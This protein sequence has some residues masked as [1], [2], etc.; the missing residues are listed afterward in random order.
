VYDRYSPTLYALLLRILGNPAEAQEVLQETFGQVWSNAF[1]FDSTS[2]SEEVWLTAMARSHGVDRLRS[3]RDAGPARPPIGNSPMTHDKFESIAALDALGAA[4]AEESSKL[5]AHIETCDS[6]RRARDDFHEAAAMMARDLDPVAP[7]PEVRHHIMD[8]LE[9]G[10][11]TLAAR[12]RSFIRPWWLAAAAVLFLALW[13]W[14][15]LAIRIAREQIASHNAEIRQL[16]VEND[17][18]TQQLTR[19]NSE[20]ALLASPTTRVIALTGKGIT[21]RA[22]LDGTGRGLLLI[23][24]LPAA[25]KSWEIFVVRTDQPKPQSVGVLAPGS[26]SVHL[27]NLPPRPQIK[28]ITAAEKRP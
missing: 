5:R 21:G 24:T 18:L 20:M 7:P 19:L 14:R 11:D 27:D 25:D 8:N 2:G 15:E 1:H 28:A 23:D 22:F 9:S 13:G 4:S 6:C 3:R 26:K 17:R 10:D 16:K 12:H